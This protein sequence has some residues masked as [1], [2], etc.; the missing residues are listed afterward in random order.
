[1]VGSRDEILSILRAMKPGLGRRFGIRDLA[2][3]GSFACGD[4]TGRSDIDILV[5]VDPEIGLDFV[6]L[7]DELEAALG[8]PV[9]LISTR[10]LRP[11]HTDAIRPEG[12]LSKRSVRLL[13]D[14]MLEATERIERY[15]VDLDQ[16]GFIAD[17]KTSD[18]VVR[19]LDILGEAAARVP[20]DFKASTPDLE[21]P[22]IVS[23]R[24]RV[25]HGCFAVNLELVWRLVV[26]GLPSVASRLRTLRD[27]LA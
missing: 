21:S 25:V 22:R 20:D 15:V 12:L 26:S 23:L 5:D 14:E 27:S 11:R 18:A 9:D 4:E 10:A 17:E 19:N 2:L 24:N 1:M 6:T 16:P 13:L 7:A 3:F 8:R